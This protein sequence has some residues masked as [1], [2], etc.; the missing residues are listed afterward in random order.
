MLNEL[1]SE[2]I[3]K[4]AENQAKLEP[5]KFYTGCLLVWRIFTKKKPADCLQEQLVKSHFT[6]SVTA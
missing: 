5:N 4:K 6:N 1:V 2:I 3:T